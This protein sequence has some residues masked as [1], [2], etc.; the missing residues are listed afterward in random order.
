MKKFR[1][2]FFKGYQKEE[3]DEY[4]ELLVSELE[5]LREKEDGVLEKE[6]QAVKELK[7]KMEE[8]QSEKEALE[9]QV[10]ALLLEEEKLRKEHSKQLTELE[11][12]MEQ[13]IEKQGIDYDAA[14]RVISIAEQEAK[15][16]SLDARAG[17]EKVLSDAK[18][19][20]EK[21]AEIAKTEAQQMKFD[22]QKEADI[23]LSEA[24]REI[25]EKRTE[26]ERLYMAAKYKLVEYLN[27]INRSQGKLIET[28]N[29]LGELIKK[30]PLR[31]DDVFSDEPLDLLSDDI[32]KK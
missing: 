16:V 25:K 27:S 1:T 18:S 30:M 4:I 10:N 29:E 21:I 17:A 3:V 15:K 7:L 26:N 11:Q 2:V 28:Y 12:R 8:A 20:A 13:Q 6:R 32:E 5:S 14:M 22:A 24:D 19:E 23:L 31:I 9:Q